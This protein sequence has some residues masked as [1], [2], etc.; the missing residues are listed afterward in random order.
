MK[1]SF[2]KIGSS[3]TAVAIALSLVAVAAP[4]K[5]A[6]GDNT[7]YSCNFQLSSSVKTL[8]ALGF[9]VLDSNE[10]GTTW[11]GTSSTTTFRTL[12]GESVSAIYAY[13]ATIANSNMDDWLITPSIRFEAGKTYQATF[14]MAKY[15]YAAHND[16]FEIKLGSDKTADA[17]TTTIIPSTTLPEK[18]GNTLWSYTATISVNETADYYIGVHATGQKVGKLGITSIEIENGIALIT[19]SAPEDFTVTPN[20]NGEK[21]AEISFKA[22]STDKNGDALESLTKVE[23]ARNGSVIKT[24][25]SPV[26]GETYS[27]TDETIAVSGDYTYTATAF[28]EAGGGDPATASVF[29]GVNVPASATNV[30]ATNLSNKSA[31]ISWEAP[32]VDKDG[33]YI[34]PALVTYDVARAPLYSSDYTTIAEGISELSYTDELLDADAEDAEASQQFYVYTVTAK[35]SQGAADEVTAYPLPLGD[36]YTVPYIESFTN[37]RAQHIFTSRSLVS[38]NYWSQTTDFDD[39][40]SAD[41]DNGMIYLNGAIGGK[42]IMFTGLIELTDCESPTL[43]FY[44]YN[45]TNCDPADNTLQVVVTA[46]DGTSK[47][48]DEFIPGDGWVKTL[49]PLNDFIGK[50]I[51]IRFIGGRQN[52]TTL[53]LDDIEISDIFPT[54]IT[55]K[56]ISAPAK[57]QTDKDYDVVVN[58]LNSGQNAIDA[59]TVELMR[60]GQVVATANEQNLPVGAYK[61]ITFKENMTILSDDEVTYQAVVTAEGDTH[62]ADNTSDEVSVK[63]QKPNY[64]TVTDLTGTIENSGAVSLSWGEPDTSKAQPYEVTEDFESYDSWATSN[65]GDWVFV[66]KDEATIAGFSEATMPGIDSY[67]Q[68]SWWV[69]DNSIDDFNNG[70]FATLSGCK[71]LA[72]MVTGIQGEGYVQND[73]WAISPELYGGPQTIVI[74][75]RSYDLEELETFEV[76]Y[77]TGSLNPD[78]FVSLGTYED[79]S[80]DWVAYEVELP[81]GAKRFAI[82]NIS[83]GKYVLMVDDVT[84]TP[85]GEPSAF[86]INGYNVYRDN[87]KLNSEPIEENEFVDET[88]DGDAHEYAVT[89]LYTAGES[90]F[91]NIYSNMSSGVALTETAQQIKIGVVGHKLYVT[92]ATDQ[93]TIRVYSIDGKTAASLRGT[94]RV[95][96][97]LPAGVYVVVVGDAAHKVIVK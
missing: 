68:Q 53:H 56:G 19:P 15:A 81:D 38:N 30:T 24:F 79:I 92:G 80:S 61:N 21:S 22:P 95:A 11:T 40:T 50:T 88:A 86:T 49:Y 65:V 47:T 73:D 67:S 77:S 4:P 87:V 66:D 69:F 85:V 93:Q 63:V 32:S 25:E 29:I 97:D 26:C 18:G 45:I 52:N 35:T 23:I 3:A 7:Y 6:D 76:L 36:P 94:N 51:A 78:D 1:Q 84:Y 83:Y 91:S 82:R 71:F 74:N 46:T 5:H 43:S 13:P 16:I 48:F 44:T 64:P 20:Q 28:T 55:L 34:N 59:Y 58:I 96:V 31:K 10:D 39:V 70:S 41:N 2:L 89:V 37:G 62:T 60:D 72:S 9:T 75:A 12:N 57:V 14:T 54:D 17:M 8:E 90:M 33:N 27:F 42:A